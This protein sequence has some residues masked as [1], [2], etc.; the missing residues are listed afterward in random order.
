MS[1]LVSELNCFGSL[2]VGGSARLFGILLCAVNS[3][4]SADKCELHIIING[5]HIHNIISDNGTTPSTCK[6]DMTRWP[7]NYPQALQ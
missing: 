1:T 4:L 5:I 3:S 2:D 7:I 6:D